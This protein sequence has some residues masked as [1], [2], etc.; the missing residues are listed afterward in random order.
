M[1]PG[2]ELLELRGRDGATAQ[3]RLFRAHEGAPGVLV[4]PA[5]G[6][7]A[8]TYDRL[9]AALAER[10]LTALIGEHRGGESSSLKPRR[11]VDYG[12]ADLLD[13]VELQCAQLKQHARGPVHFLGHSLG[14]HLGVVGLSRWFEPGGRLVVVASGTV[15]WREWPRGQRL[16]LFVR[17]QAAGLIASTLGYFPG[18]RLRFGGVQGQTLIR[19]WA[20]FARHGR[21][22]SHARGPL[23]HALETLRPEV[24]A[25]HVVG[26]TLAP[27]ESTQGL[28]A[29]LPNAHVT[30]K[31]V[32]P[33]A[34]PTRLD[35]HF[36]W[37]REPQAVADAVRVF[38][39]Q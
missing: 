18:D 2:P 30:W 3:S 19:E 14:G 20:G 25:L 17:S 29:K 38:V 33:P 26:D 4:S 34:Q 24:L 36:R 32:E 31:D 7:H 15:H 10:G 8:R 12:Y 37:M 23:E 16:S 28:L 6:V 13:D 11:G 35:P 27:R 1:T 39:T 22:H 5:M 9:G 21:V